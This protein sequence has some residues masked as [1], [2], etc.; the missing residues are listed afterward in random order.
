MDKTGLI[1]EIPFT[2]GKVKL[3]NG[4]TVKREK[5]PKK[6]SGHNQFF[7]GQLFTRPGKFKNSSKGKNG[8]GRGE[9]KIRGNE[10][11]KHRHGKLLSPGPRKTKLGGKDWT[12]NRLSIFIGTVG[13]RENGKMTWGFRGKKAGNHKG[14]GCQKTS[15]DNKRESGHKTSKVGIRQL[16]IGLR[17]KHHNEIPRGLLADDQVCGGGPFGG[18]N[19]LGN[20]GPRQGKQAKTTS[21]AGVKRNQKI[22]KRG[23]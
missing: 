15:F 17:R 9:G 2:L 21:T 12:P 6:Q 3:L 7:Q 16:T 5:T 13:K 14:R 4:N 11:N 22:Q 8:F 23:I 20:R 18:K 19:N 10:G 1:R